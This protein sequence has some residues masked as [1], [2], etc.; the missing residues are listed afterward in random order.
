M[1]KR[2]TDCP[3]CS[4]GK[5]WVCCPKREC[6]LQAM[7]EQRGN[8]ARGALI[9]LLDTLDSLDTRA[10]FKWGKKDRSEFLKMAGMQE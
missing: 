9:Q 6:A 1:G 3:V 2:I 5:P 10:G 8:M 4:E 7:V